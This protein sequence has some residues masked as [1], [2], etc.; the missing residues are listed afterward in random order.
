MKSIEEQIE[1]L[2]QQLRPP[3]PEDTFYYFDVASLNVHVCL[4]RYPEYESDARKQWNKF[5]FASTSKTEVE[6]YADCYRRLKLYQLL[7]KKAEKEFPVIWE[8][9]WRSGLPLHFGTDWNTV[10]DD[11]H[12]GVWVSGVE[13]NRIVTLG[14]VWFARNEDRLEA[15][16]VCGIDEAFQERCAKLGLGGA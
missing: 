1:A 11:P 6:E 16:K 12:G 13:S 2:T 9:E 5:N 7:G 15:L 3:F 10:C 14:G 8:A 4:K